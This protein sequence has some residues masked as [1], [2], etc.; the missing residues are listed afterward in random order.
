MLSEVRLPRKTLEAKGRIG[1]T[2]TELA[3]DCVKGKPLPGNFV[4]PLVVS[5]TFKQGFVLSLSLSFSVS[6][7]VFLPPLSLS[8]LFS[9]SLAYPVF[10]LFAFRLAAIFLQVNESE[11]WQ[12]GDPSHVWGHAGRH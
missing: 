7:S 6:F 10:S 11:H 1:D 3:L 4:M 12:T 5:Y 8:L 9:V 2:S